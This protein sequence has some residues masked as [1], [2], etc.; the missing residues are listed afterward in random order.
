MAGQRGCD[1][2]AIRRIGM[3]MGVSEIPCPDRPGRSESD[4]LN[5]PKPARQ[6]AYPREVSPDLGKPQDSGGS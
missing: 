5:P 3:E 6:P 2:Q 4:R 1:D